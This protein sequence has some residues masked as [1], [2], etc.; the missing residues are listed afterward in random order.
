MRLKRFV[1]KKETDMYEL[2][3]DGKY[4]WVGTYNECLIKLQKACHQSW[5]W[6]MKYE[7]YAIDPFG[8]G[9]RYQNIHRDYGAGQNFYTLVAYDQRGKAVGWIDYSEYKGKAHIEMIKVNKDLRRQG[10]AINMLKWMGKEFPYK[11]VKWGMLTPE[12]SKLKKYA[13]KILK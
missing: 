12:G 11:T 7:G 10:I 2:T 13:D 8:G 9:Y 6:C 5:D 3:R 4:M 1:E